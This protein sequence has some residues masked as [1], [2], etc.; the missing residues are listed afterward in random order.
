MGLAGWCGRRAT[1]YAYLLGKCTPA[2]PQQSE[3]P[4]RLSLGRTA[5]WRTRAGG[6]GAGT[7][8]TA[9]ERRGYRCAPGQLGAATTKRRVAS[10]CRTC[11]ATIYIALISVAS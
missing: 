4:A 10:A 3:G 7:P 9:P 6:I 11:C 5:L 2:Q 8:A 1:G